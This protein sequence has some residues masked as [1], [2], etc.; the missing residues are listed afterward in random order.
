MEDLPLTIIPHVLRQAVCHLID[1]NRA[2]GTLLILS[3]L[4][5]V[6]EVALF[7][8][9]SK[10]LAAAVGT[11]KFTHVKNVS[12]LSRYFHL[13]KLRLAQWTD[14]VPC[15]PLI[16]TGAADEALAITAS[17]EVFQYIRANWTD[18]LLQDLFELRFGTIY[19]E[20]SQFVC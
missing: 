14:R 6:T 2:E 9:V 8:F 12:N 4:G 3:A 13:L 15:Q 11:R 10:A 7:V 16:K 18:E 5:T 19:T 20:F 17:S 1:I